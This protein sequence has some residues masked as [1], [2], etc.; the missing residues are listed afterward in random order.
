M[1]AFFMIESPLK[2]P[3][4]IAQR[5]VFDVGL[6]ALRGFVTIPSH[7]RHPPGLGVY[8]VADPQVSLDSPVH[9]LY[10]DGKD[11]ED[12]ELHVVQLSRIGE[13]NRRIDSGRGFYFDEG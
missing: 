4:E 1:I 3:F 11:I 6:P 8:D 10:R 2:C 7:Q 13:S 5:E 12:L 9:V